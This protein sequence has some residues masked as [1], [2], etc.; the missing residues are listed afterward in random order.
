MDIKVLSIDIAKRVFQLHG[1]DKC[2]KGVYSRKCSRAELLGVIAELQPQYVVMEACATSNHWGREL[3]QR[4]MKV[5]LIAPQHVKPYVRGNKTDK[6]DAAAIVEAYRRDGMK[7]VKV[8]TPEQQGIQVVHRV[9]EQA[10]SRRT[11]TIN[12][13]RALAEEFGI[14]LPRSQSQLRV[15]FLEKLEEDNPWLDFRAKAVLRELYEEL[16]H[17][18]ERVA[19]YDAQLKRVVDEVPICKRLTAERGVGPVVAT[20][21]VASIGNPRTYPN[22][23]AVGAWLG[24]TPR[25]YT[26][27]GQRRLFGITKRGDKYLRKQLVH[28]ARSVVWSSKNRTDELSVWIQG[29]VERRGHNRAVV[30]VANKMARQL[31]AIMNKD[32]S[33]E[34]PAVAV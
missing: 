19:R 5:R 14:V 12:E 13:L 32:D 24:L 18:D 28:G 27:A 6:A 34:S 10:V 11:A 25:E 22:G 16:V 31:W 33:W 2:W 30:A 20:A 21:F 1:V 23:R 4:G 15:E 3:E 26:T 9:R 29:L 7:F 8:K 17:L